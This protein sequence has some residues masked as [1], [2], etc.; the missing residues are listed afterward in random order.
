MSDYKTLMKTNCQIRFAVAVAAKD[1][2]IYYLKPPSLIF[3]IFFPVCLFCAFAFGR[4]IPPILLLPGMLGMSLFFVSS[5]STPVIAPW[6][7]MSKT[8]ERL[9]STPA[10][11]AA[12]ISGDILS[13]ALYGIFVSS[14][15]LALVYPIVGVTI[16]YPGILILNI[17]L[18]AI[19]F[20]AMGSLLSTLPT[21]TPAHIMLLTNL[22]RFPLVFISGVFIPI[23][24]LPDWGKVLSVFSPLS[25][26]CELARHA[27]LGKGFFSP[28]LCLTVLSAF[29]IGFFAAS[30][31]FH[32]KS[33]PKRLG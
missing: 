30:V 26:S 19:C 14:F 27:L 25:Y 31:Y 29:S 23:E 22:V 32:K 16:V 4:N 10:S 1:M 11:I 21:D 28:K 12:I 3:G 8:L 20:S 5:G 6:E 24:S 13:G 33:M 2:R 18:S 7:T 9:I 17:I 15:L